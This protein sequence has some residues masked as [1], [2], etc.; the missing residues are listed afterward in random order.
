MRTTLDVDQKLLDAAR[1]R[2]EERGTTLTEFVEEALAAALA[3]QSAGGG[4]YKLHWK[5]HRGRVLPGID[6]ADRESLFD[7][8]DGRR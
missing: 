4:A 6:I 2:A 5:T 3:P 7:A 1:Q 8:M